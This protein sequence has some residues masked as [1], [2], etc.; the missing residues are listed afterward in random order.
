MSRKAAMGKIGDNFLTETVSFIKKEVTSAEKALEHKAKQI[1]MT[2]TIFGVA[3][4]I[5]VG[6]VGTALFQRYV[7]PE[8]VTPPGQPP[9]V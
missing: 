2:S 1:A 9:R 5:V 7:T 4:G 3:I 8:P 6:I